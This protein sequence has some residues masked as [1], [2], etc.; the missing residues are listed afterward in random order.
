MSKKSFFIT[1]GLIFALSFG[2]YFFVFK[3]IN[4]TI[5]N[6][7]A[8]KKPVILLFSASW[9]GSCKK[10]KPILNEVLEKH[11]E[12]D[13]FEIGSN[14]N[15]VRK[16]VLFKKYKVKGIPTLILFKEGKEVQRLTGVQTA[17]DL[18]K[19]FSALK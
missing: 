14:L 19:S 10:Q 12:I 15:K 13:Y 6:K 3:G 1:L 17:Q 5:E 18:E 7:I 16:K 4:Q 8:S 2:V 9:C 11:K